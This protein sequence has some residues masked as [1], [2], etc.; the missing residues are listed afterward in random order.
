MA[1]EGEIK[2]YTLA[3]V[4]EHKHPKGPHADVWIVIHDKVYNVT[5]FLDEV[6]SFHS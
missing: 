2:S 4:G 1:V 6:K 5:K 3:E